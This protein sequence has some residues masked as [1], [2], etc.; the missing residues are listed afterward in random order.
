MSGAINDLGE[1]NRIGPKQVTTNLQAFV[2]PLLDELGPV[3]MLESEAFEAVSYPN[4]RAF[5]ACELGL[6]ER[7]RRGFFPRRWWIRLTK[8]GWESE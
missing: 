8:T 5:W 1:W 3:W 6:A 4:M 2:R 7:Q